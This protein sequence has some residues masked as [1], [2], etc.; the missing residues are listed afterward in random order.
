M[1]PAD[2][3]DKVIGDVVG[4]LRPGDIVIDGGNS[5]WKDTER[6][7]T[8][9]E[10]FG[11]TYV[12]MG[13]SGGEDGALNG[14][15]MMFGGARSAWELCRLDLEKI[16]ARASDGA[17][18][19]DFIGARGSGHFVKMVHNAIEYSDMQLIA[20]T[21]DILSNVFGIP[22]ADA[23]AV[24]SRWNQ[25]PLRSYLIEI[26]AK[27]LAQT[28]G[29]LPLVD[30]IL[31]RAGQKG[32]GKWA[33]QDSF[34]LMTAT[35]AFAEAVHARVIS[36]AKSE[37]V[38]ASKLIAKHSIATAAPPITVDDLEN[39]LYAAKIACYAQG[40]AIIQRASGEFG[41]DV[42]V[43]ACARIWRGGCIIR[44]DFLNDI[45]SHYTAQTPNLMTISFFLNLMDQK[46][47]SWRKVVAA[48]ALAA[49]PAP[50]FASTLNYFDA[51]TRERLPANLIQGLRDFFGAHTYE[52]V[53]RPGS[54]HTI[55]E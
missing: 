40:L 17:P 23:A 4:H 29:E 50:L 51:Y 52:R 31:D 54:F 1:V 22:A 26:T 30:L 16:A 28:D 32:T 38:A 53:D 55:W 35:P 37:R 34:D 41:Y 14:P 44:A 7:Q 18:C 48:C 21:Y 11:I 19:V 42:D 2:A 47:E 43:A 46:I 13:I 25:G 5:H 33:A 39:A 9:L 36:N 15:S 6:R 10:Q 20:E 12:G 8:E 3:V 45:A 27:V 49:I 24:F